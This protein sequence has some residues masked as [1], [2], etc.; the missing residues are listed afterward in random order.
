MVLVVWPSLRP[1]FEARRGVYGRVDVV[2]TGAGS[3]KPML[4]QSGQKTAPLHTSQ[5]A[6][7]K[8][9]SNPGRLGWWRVCLLF[10]WRSG[11]FLMMSM[12]LSDV[13]LVVDD[14][15][16]NREM[17]VAYLQVK[18][19]TV[20]ASPNGVTALSLADALRP[21]VILIDLATAGLDGLETT[22]R[23]KA[24]ESTRDATIVAV[25]GQVATDREDAYRAGCDFFIPKPYDVATLAKFLDWLLVHPSSAR[26]LIAPELT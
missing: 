6:I 12:P 17:M 23:L 13:I 18:G 19:L 24:N 11:T 3:S 1:P 15:A 2:K 25:T 5:T 10:T 14:D 20:H 21:R 26:P 7:H 22:R 8:T 9:P 16:G 4:R